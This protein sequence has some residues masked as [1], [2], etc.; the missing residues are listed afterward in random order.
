MIRKNHPN[1]IPEK[2]TVRQF[3]PSVYILRDCTAYELVRLNISA[4]FPNVKIVQPHIAA[5]GSHLTEGLCNYNGLCD[6]FSS[7]QS[8]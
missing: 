4:F 5:L 2:T 6:Y 7:N 8:T 3:A 1:L